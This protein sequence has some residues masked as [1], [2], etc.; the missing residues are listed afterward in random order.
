M[1][2]HIFKNI[3][4]RKIDIFANTYGAD[5]NTIFRLDEKL[6]HPLEYG[7]YREKCFKELLQFVVDKNVGITDGF[8]ISAQNS[9]STQC[10]VILYESNVIPLID[11]NIAKFFPVEI[12]KGIGEIKSNLSKAQFTE[13]LQK[14]ARNKM[15]TE[16]RRGIVSYREGF[17]GEYEYLTSFLV[18]N[19]L[20]FDIS[21]IDF[22]E[23][24]YKDIPRQFWHN[25]I[26]SLEDGFISYML[27]FKE[28]PKPMQANFIANRGNIN[29]PPVIW[30]YPIHIENENQFDCPYNIIGARSHNKYHHVMH[31]LT[32]IKS[33]L[34]NQTQFEFD[35][36]EYLDFNSQSILIK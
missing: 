13:A 16:E 26:L 29:A 28:L 18:C 19:K 15:L 1:G 23:D 5:S 7:I 22:K 20:N 35:L 31:F 17:F 36:I 2:S 8:I 11:N 3:L 10:D 33:N 21:S 32:S 27:D 30:Q 24:I 9:V 34:E 12:V 4:E 14:L 6:F 25:V